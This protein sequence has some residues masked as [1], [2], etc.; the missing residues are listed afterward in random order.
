MRSIALLAVAAALMGAC[1]SA[2]YDEL[3]QRSSQAIPGTLSASLEP[4]GDVEPRLDPVTAIARAPL[5]D[6][7]EIEVS[8]ARVHD[9][10]EQVSVG[11]AWVLV[12]RGVCI[13]ED[14]GELV[15]DA[16][17]AVPGDGLECTR[18]T[19]LLVALDAS[20]GASLFTITGYDESLSWHPDVADTA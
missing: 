14:K 18:A 13:R 19:F 4:P 20:T 10:L 11:P 12:A 8:L 15:S 7:T 6:G 3:R 17:G 9:E 5:P 1:T 16:R 2:P